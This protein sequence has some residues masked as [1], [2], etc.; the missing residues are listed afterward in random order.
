HLH[1]AL[2]R[3]GH[4]VNPLTQS[5]GVNHQVSPGM[6]TLFD[7][8]KDNYLAMLSKLPDLGG[9]FHVRTVTSL[10]AKAAVGQAAAHLASKDSHRRS[11]HHWH[12][13]R[14]ALAR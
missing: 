2:E 3:G 10:G 14:T 8:F 5:I 9:H 13:W 1:F 4:Y 12:S 7:K 11:R 6:R